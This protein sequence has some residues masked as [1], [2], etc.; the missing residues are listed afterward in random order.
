MLI[1][2]AFVAVPIDAVFVEPRSLEVT[3]HTVPIKSLSPSHEGLRVVQISDLHLSL[4]V[5]RSFI[6]QAVDQCNSLDPD[7]VVVTGDF[8]S[9]DRN[10]AQPCAR[11]L[12]GLQAPKGVFAVLG[13]HDH[14]IDAPHVTRSL[15]NEGITVLTNKNVN[16]DGLRLAG[17][18]DMWAGDCDVAGA[19]RG[20]P[21]GDPLVVL[22]HSPLV[23]PK[24]EQRDC[25]VLAGHTHGG[26]VNVPSLTKPLLAMAQ[27]G[28]Y[29]AG[30][31]DQGKAWMYV[32]RGIGGTPIR[33]RAKPEVSLFV[34]KS[35]AR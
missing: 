20:I 1:G 4:C 35:G 24:L 27:C 8:I 10:K 19:L 11:L 13:N 17:V 6:S 26:H 3:R 23:L 14:W 33:F 9:H 5:P 34:L 28:S 22:S 21:Q 30:W 12:G 32:N 7:I 29:T 31:F 2:A 18:D 25:L 16:V 15:E